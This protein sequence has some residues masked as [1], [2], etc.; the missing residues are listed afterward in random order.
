M[1]FRKS[2]QRFPFLFHPG[3]FYG[4][5]IFQ[6][7]GLIILYISKLTAFRTSLRGVV[8][9]TFFLYRLKNIYA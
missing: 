5:I 8:D 7:L 4:L 3:L 6:Y 1:F 2:L 9:T